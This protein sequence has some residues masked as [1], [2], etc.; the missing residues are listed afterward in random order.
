MRWF[1]STSS[2]SRPLPF[3]ALSTGTGLPRDKMTRIEGA[4]R[5]LQSDIDR[6]IPHRLTPTKPPSLS[7]P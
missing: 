4:G 1:T 6:K 7:S 5:K 2:A 3:Y